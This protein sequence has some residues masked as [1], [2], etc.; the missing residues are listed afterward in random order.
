MD[1]EA[2]DRGWV[3]NGNLFILSGSGG[4]KSFLMNHLCRSYYDQ[5]MHILIV[6]VGH[7]YQ[8]LCR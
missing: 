1:V 8:V 6:D 2:R 4:G 7:S 3:Q 5:E